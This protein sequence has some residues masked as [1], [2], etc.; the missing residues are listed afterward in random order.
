MAHDETCGCEVCSGKF[1][2]AEYIAMARETSEKIGFFQA[3]VLHTHD[4]PGFSYTTGLYRFGVPELIVF[5]LPIQY[6]NALFS[7][8]HGLLQDGLT[9]IE[10]GEIRT[11]LAVG[12]R[13]SFRHCDPAKVEEYTV[14]TKRFCEEEGRSFEV[15]QLIWPDPADNFPWEKNYDPKF[16]KM[17]PELWN[18]R[19]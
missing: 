10:D 9:K 17:Q 5:A 2:M 16:K 13:T 3:N 14:L 11:D 19:N 12:L 7:H 1:S 18:T 8:V 15:A 6:S 4:S